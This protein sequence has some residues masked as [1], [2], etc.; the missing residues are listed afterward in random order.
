MQGINSSSG[1]NKI[2]QDIVSP[3][4]LEIFIQ[5]KYN[6]TIPSLIFEY[7]SEENIDFEINELKNFYSLFGE[8]IDFILKGKISIVLFKTFFSAERC[9]IYLLDNDNFKE[10]KRNNFSIRWFDYDKDIN[11]I[12]YEN[13]KI[14]ETF[15]NC[16][17]INIKNIQDNNI[18][19]NSKNINNTNKIQISTYNINNNTNN[20]MNNN[21]NNIINNYNS[22]NIFMPQ[23]IMIQQ[24]NQLK[25]DQSM[26]MNTNNI[27][28]LSSN[29]QNFPN[30]NSQN[31]Q[32]L[33]NMHPMQYY[34]GMEN[35]IMHQGMNM[36]LILNQNINNINNINNIFAIQ[37]SNQPYNNQKPYSSNLNISIEEK[38]YGKFTCKYEILIPNDKDFQVARRLIGSKGC[39][40][41]RILNECKQS[42]NINDNVKLRL[43]GKGSGYKE[44]PQNKESEDP[45]HL[46]ISAKNQEEMKR[47]CELVDSLLDKIYDEYKKYC[48]KN[49]IM[50][51]ATQLA[52]RIDCGNSLHKGK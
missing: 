9:R 48:S 26:S 19:Q 21:M 39:N 22:N 41:K 42:N 13:K 4:K 50:P 7:L 32:N 2:I 10:N 52:K 43:R 16:N 45:L 5:Q 28:N 24:N 29:L 3:E 31:Y 51:I 15:H 11:I 23:N 17:L 30:L 8:I 33:Q 38:N 6:I 35:L 40:M 36:P 20:N 12:P 47:A 14:F 18:Q 37:L 49:N 44:G 34:N 46:C 27:N 1:N 25:M